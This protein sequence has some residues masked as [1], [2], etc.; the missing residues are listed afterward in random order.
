MSGESVYDYAIV[1]AGSAGLQLLLAMLNEESLVSA[2]IV[3]IDRAEH[4]DKTWCFWETENGKY[5]ELITH[6]WIKGKFHGQQESVDL[7]LESLSYKMLKS[8]D[9]LEFAKRTTADKKNVKWIHADVSEIEE[10]SPHLIS[11]TQGKVSARVVFDSRPLPME[12]PPGK[13]PNILQHFKGKFIHT[14][15]PVFDPSEFTMMDYRLRL[16]DKT[17][18]TY[19]LPSSPTEALVEFTLFTPSLIED[20]EYDEYIDRYCH[21]ILKI[22]DYEVVDTESGVIPMTTYPFHK[23]SS[24]THLRIGTPGGWVK[25]GSGYSFAFGQR[26]SEKIAQALANG[27]SP[28]VLPFRKRSR[29]FDRIFL[30]LLFEQNHLGPE[31]FAQMYARN[32]VGTILRFLDEQTTFREDLGIIS[33]FNKGPFIRSFWR[34]LLGIPLKK[35]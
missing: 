14:S 31:V 19:V 3:V 34:D 24:D 17:S 13:H 18:F 20:H 11:S 1:G 12:G 5:D 15:S 26:I 7:Q 4:V 27:D 9:L 16:E 33:S 29:F 32:T 10:T 25:P 21:E 6:S 23:R 28:L 2:S 8:R 30:R 35:S 22:E